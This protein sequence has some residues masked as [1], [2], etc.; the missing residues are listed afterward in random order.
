MESV[1]TSALRYDPSLETEIAVLPLPDLPAGRLVYAPTGPLDPDYDDVRSLQ[2][3]AARGLRRALKA[4]IRKL[5]VVL[6]E[7]PN[8]ENS[9]L[10]TLLGVLEALYMVRVFFITKS[11]N[12][13][14]CKNMIKYRF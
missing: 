11:K 2:E 4:G 10:V 12:E 14:I 9:Q 6:E 5:L 13:N 8:F 7:Y 3:T 1:I